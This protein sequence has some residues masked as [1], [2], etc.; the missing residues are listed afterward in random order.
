MLQMLKPTEEISLNWLYKGAK[1]SPCTF[2]LKSPSA[3]VIYPGDIISHAEMN[4]ISAMV[5][6]QRGTWTSH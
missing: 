5:A 4:V 1:A 3:M 6:Q 2:Q